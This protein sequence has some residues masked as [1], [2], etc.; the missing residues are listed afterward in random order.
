M[1]DAFTVESGRR[2]A[3]LLE[4][5]VPVLSQYRPTA[6]RMLGALDDM[7]YRIGA[8]HVLDVL[9]GALIAGGVFLLLW[10]GFAFSQ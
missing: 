1:G 10:T 9:A 4:P 2:A 6:L 5:Q 3:R 7:L 8:P